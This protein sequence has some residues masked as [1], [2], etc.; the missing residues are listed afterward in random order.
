MLTRKFPFVS[1][2]GSNAY[3]GISQTS[4]RWKLQ[5]YNTGTYTEESHGYPVNIHTEYA[6]ILPPPLSERMLAVGEEV[7]GLAAESCR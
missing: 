6:F 4:L 3:L 1:L 5:Q 2:L 7:R